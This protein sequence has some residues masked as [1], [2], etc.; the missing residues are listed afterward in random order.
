[1]TLSELRQKEVINTRDGRSLGRVCD[2]VFCPCEGRVTAIVV[3]GEFCLSA[4]LRG[5]KAGVVIPWERL[6]KVGDDVIL[7]DLPDLCE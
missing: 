5:E 4:L 6:C 1:M 3:P 2:I 7:A